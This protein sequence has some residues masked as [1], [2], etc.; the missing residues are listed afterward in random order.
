MGLGWLCHGFGWF[1]LVSAYHIWFSIFCHIMLWVMVRDS[2]WAYDLFFISYAMLSF[3]YHVLCTQLYYRFQITLRVFWYTYM[4]AFRFDV[5]ISVRNYDIGLRHFVKYIYLSQQMTYSVC[6]YIFRISV[7]IGV[8]GTQRQ[9]L[10]LWEV[11][12]RI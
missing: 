2:I 9:S 6:F 8:D 11:M 7:S 12:T 1:S 4:H 5:P 10:H 3:C